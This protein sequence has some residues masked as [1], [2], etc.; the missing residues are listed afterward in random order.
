MTDNILIVYFYSSVFSHIDCYTI[1][2]PAI[3]K[4]MS[5]V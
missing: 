3:I 2:E 5:S 1:Y 4:A